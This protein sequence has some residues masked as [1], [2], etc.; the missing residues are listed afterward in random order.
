ME[1]SD[2]PSEDETSANGN[3]SGE[4][5][6]PEHRMFARDAVLPAIAGSGGEDGGDA[7]GRGRAD[8][9]GIHTLRWQ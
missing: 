2:R 9:A 3:V 1:Q 5:S 6:S 4:S 8:R 7:V